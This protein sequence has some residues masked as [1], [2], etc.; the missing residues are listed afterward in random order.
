MLKRHLRHMELAKK[1]ALLD[2]SKKKFYL[3]AVIAKGNKILSIGVN[4]YKKTHTKCK[5]YYSQA[6]HAEM[7]AILTAEVD[8]K[9]ATIYIYRESKAG[10][11]GCSRPCHRC[12]YNLQISGIKA[13][14]FLNLAGVITIEKGM[15]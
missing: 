4:S 8:I 10:K 5:D 7:H 2:Q 14:Y 1:I 13:I 12:M 15:V 11:R 9:G 3:G 6:M